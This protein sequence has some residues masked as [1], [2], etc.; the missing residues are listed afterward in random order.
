MTVD[1]REQR[2]GV[3]VEMTGLTRLH[4]A[5]VAA[6][7]FHGRT[8][9]LNDF[10]DTFA[11]VDTSGRIWKFTKD[12]SIHCQ[13]K[14]GGQKIDAGKDHAVEFVTPICTYKDI[15]TIQELLRQLRKAGAFVNSSCGVHIHVDA[16]P[17]TAPKL[18]NLV[19]I[20]A[21]KEDMI[22]KALQVHSQREIHYCRK[23]EPRFLS[24]INTFR[25]QTMEQLKNIWYNGEDGSHEHY[26]GSRYHCLNLHSVFQKGTIEF[27]AFNGDIHAGKIKAYIQFCLA[28]TAQAYNQRCASPLRTVSDNEKYTFRVWLLRLGMIGREFETARLHLLKHLEGNP[29]WKDPAQAQRQSERLQNQRVRQQLLARPTVDQDMTMTM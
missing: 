28:I 16:A 24:E 17:F 27:R 11:A 6:Q 7:F 26:H 10:Y 29:A 12:S 25:P 22:Y 21:A 19:N 13:K 14:E 8:K 9:Y 15:E 1:L 23:I 4:A 2:F 18:R 20:V 5:E 3:E